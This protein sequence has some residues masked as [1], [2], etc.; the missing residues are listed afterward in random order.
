MTCIKTD[1]HLVQWF[2]HLVN[3]EMG[4]KTSHI[5]PKM[6]YFHGAKFSQFCPIKIRLIFAFLS[7]VVFILQISHKVSQVSM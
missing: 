1:K 4:I 3:V 5:Y 7:L 2:T 6:E